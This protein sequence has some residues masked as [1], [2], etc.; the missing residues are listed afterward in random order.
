MTELVDLTAHIEEGMPNHP[1][2]G[3]SPLFLTGTRRNHEDSEATWRGRGVEDMSFKNGFVYIAEH[4]GTHL[5]APVHV[6]PEGASIDEV[7]LEECH[8]PG[9]WLDISDAGPKGLVGPDELESAAEEA[10]VEV[11]AGDAVLLHTGWDRYVPDDPETYLGEHPGLSAA[12]AEWLHDR[13]VSLVGIDC[14]NMDVASDPAL[15]AHRVFLRRDVP[16]KHTL[17]VENLRNVDSIPAH[18]FTF[19]AVPLPLAGATASPV[20]A[21]AVVE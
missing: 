10:G 9:V 8:G 19:S 12:G 17:V 7:P 1:A 14:G 3:R 6:H 11:R 4:N 15:P 5:D 2:H 21:F 18:R 13:D 20:R 16:E